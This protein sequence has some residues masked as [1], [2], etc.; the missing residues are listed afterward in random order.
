MKTSHKLILIIIAITLVTP[1]IIAKMLKDKIDNNDFTLHSNRGSHLP[2]F[3]HIKILTISKNL[4]NVTI[5]IKINKGDTSCISS[6]HV[7]ITDVYRLHNDTLV[8]DAY[9]A[10]NREIQIVSPHLESI[11]LLNNSEV[12]IYSYKGY[13]LFENLQIYG[14]NHSSVNFQ[15]TKNNHPPFAYKHLT[16]HLSDKSSATLSPELHVGQLNLFMKDKANLNIDNNCQINMIEGK[17]D[18]TTNINANFSIYK[19]MKNILP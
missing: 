6:S 3:K 11:T 15:S 4:Y 2:P 7:P 9:K 10:K 13:G 18:S 19:K 16:I 12:E 14:M 8:V 5:P 17:V 1:I